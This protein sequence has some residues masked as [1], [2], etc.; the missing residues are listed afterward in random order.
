MS[1]DIA[2]LR[3]DTPACLRRIHFNN[4]GS[5]L[6]PT[7][8][9][10]SQ[11][12]HLRLEAEIG[13]Y[14]AADVAHD[15]L[16]AF[17]AA[18]ARAVG[19]HP[20]EIAFVENATRAWDMVFY[21]FDW[22]AGDKVLTSRADYN[23]NMVAYWQV[24]RKHGVE[25]VMI[26]DDAH[27][28]IDV[29]ALDEAIDDRV[30]L[31]SV[32]HIPTNSGLLAPA[33]AVG[34]V[35]RKH[36][37]PYLLDACQSVGQIPIDVEDIG[38]TM[39]ATTGRKYIRGPRGTGFLWVREDWIEKLEPPLLDNHAAPWVAVD[40]YEIRKDARRFE[41]WEC[42]FAG[43]VS[44][45]AALN[46]MLAVGMDDI[47]ARVQTL[48]HSLRDHLQALPGVTLWDPGQEKCGLVTFTVDGWE[49]KAIRDR[50][51]QENINVSASTTQ[52]TR[53]EQRDRSVTETVR[54]SVH[55][56]NTEEE[57]DR[58]L[59]AVRHLNI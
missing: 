14:E 50:F 17:Y 59:S 57:I 23:S 1:L 42:N 21:A 13:G 3:D 33:A 18:A 26:P 10:E 46:Y 22:Q 31:I 15:K 43:K 20:G 7:P 52:L 47:W 5:S 4:A 39:L 11:I 36:D 28:A 19:G 6:P 49:A 58:F 56:Y 37:I 8:V 48:S 51:R 30:R 55:Y 12:A 32:S 53:A 24:A 40:R 35:A 29:N 27:G 25:I 45:G 54:A 41:N 38:C 2:S 9:L 16:E 44:L 34:A